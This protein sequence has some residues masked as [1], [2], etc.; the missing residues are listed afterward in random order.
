[1]PFFPVSSTMYV[2]T[3]LPLNSI[4]LVIIIKLV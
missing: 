1:M 4:K 3:W 2:G